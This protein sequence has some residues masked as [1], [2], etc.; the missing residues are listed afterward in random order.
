MVETNLF[1]VLSEFI[2][3]FSSSRTIISLILSLLKCLLQS[4]D[5]CLFLYP[6]SILYSLQ[7]CQ[8]VCSKDAKLFLAALEC[9][10]LAL[11]NVRRAGCGV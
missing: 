8:S 3:T 9:M 6:Q 1:P 11:Q 10:E 7:T 5:V 4:R 2:S